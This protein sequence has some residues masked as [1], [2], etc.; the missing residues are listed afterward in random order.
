M[1]NTESNSLNQSLT[2]HS[3]DS[4]GT[5]DGPG[6]RLVIFLQGCNLSCSYCHN[7]DTICSSEGTIIAGKD[8]IERAIKMKPYFAN[9]GGITFSG[10][11]PLLQATELLPIITELHTQ[12]IHVAIDTNATVNTENAQRIITEYADLVMFDIKASNPLLFHKITGTHGFET[13][14]HTIS[15]REKSQKPYWLRYVLIPGITDSTECFEWIISSFKHNKY[16]EQIEILPYH[17]LGIHKW[18]ALGKQYTLS[19]IKEN[20]QEQLQRAEKFLSNYFSTIIR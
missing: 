10:G 6:I 19:H 7:P 20:T 17:T 8:I 13:M 2:I 14:L 3:I 12:S 16:L 4:F 18:E 15:L 1:N 9:S 11:E 5:H